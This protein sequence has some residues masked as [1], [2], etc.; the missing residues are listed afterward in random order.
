MDQEDSSGSILKMRTISGNETVEAGERVI[1][2]TSGP[3]SPDSAARTRGRR[4]RRRFWLVFLAW[5]VPLAML[6]CYAER[7]QSAWFSPDTFQHRRQNY[8]V[9]PVLRLFTL[10]KGP[11]RTY[12]SPLWAH[13]SET[14]CLPP[15]RRDPPRWHRIYGYNIVG[16]PSLG[17]AKWIDWVDELR[18]VD[19]SNRNPELA[20]ILWPGVV[21]LVHSEHY[22]EAHTLMTVD[23]VDGLPAEELR[24]DVER[25]LRMCRP[26]QGSR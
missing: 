8:Y 3:V 10:W 12:R 4:R 9:E 22:G 21:K 24:A 26:A 15:P 6:V 25:F 1:E 23:S 16:R 7:R 11:V 19:W 17:K 18:L 20:G 13:L 14:G 2:R 5:V